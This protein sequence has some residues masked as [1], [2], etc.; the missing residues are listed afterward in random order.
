MW[1]QTIFKRDH[2][3]V[4]ILYRT[5]PIN[6]MLCALTLVGL[7]YDHQAQPPTIGILTRYQ[8]HL[9]HDIS[10]LILFLNLGYLV[11]A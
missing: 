2:R 6:L 11:M 10:S 5:K 9:G 1:L 8:L 7:Y 4:Q 3:I